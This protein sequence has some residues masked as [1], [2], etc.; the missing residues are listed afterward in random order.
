[1]PDEMAPE[2]IAPLVVWLCTDAAA[3]VNGQDF[4]VGGNS[5]RLYSL[6]T[7]VKTIYRD[8]GW[9]LDSLDRVFPQTLGQGLANPMPAQNA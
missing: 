3:E 2:R 4:G 8:G 5:I 1:M 6:P 9:D 7:P